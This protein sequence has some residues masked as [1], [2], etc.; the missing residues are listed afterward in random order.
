MTET[1]LSGMVIN[2]IDS[3]DTYQKLV[4]AGQIGENNISFVESEDTSDSLGITGASVGDII[5]VK[6]VDADGK[7]TAWETAGY[8]LLSESTGISE[9]VAMLEFTGLIGYNDFVLVANMPKASGSARY[10]LFIN[11][12]Q[13][14]SGLG[15]YFLHPNSPKNVI[16]G[17]ACNF[18][19]KHYM[20]YGT[21]QEQNSPYNQ[22]NFGVSFG[23]TLLGDNESIESLKIASDKSDV[24]IPAQTSYKFYGRYINA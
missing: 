1:K 16:L 8:T 19:D 7:P 2:K 9:A 15:N 22:D 23:Q 24:L 11:N 21:S 20:T 6:K 14:S 12:R 10:R 4:E 3:E 13:V 17:V 18:I 5:K